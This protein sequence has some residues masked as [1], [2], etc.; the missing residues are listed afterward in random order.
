MAILTAV[1]IYW[2][3]DT[4][5][6]VTSEVWTLRVRSA[7]KIPKHTQLNQAYQ[8]IYRAM[9]ERTY[10]QPITTNNRIRASRSRTAI[11]GSLGGDKNAANS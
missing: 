8:R 9:R 4:C 6:I 1:S 5:R 3:L 2:P 7:M 11:K 10:A